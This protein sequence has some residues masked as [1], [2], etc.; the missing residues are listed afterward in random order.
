MIAKVFIWDNNMVTVFDEQGCQVE[1][2]QGSLAQ[3][4]DLILA[5]C[6]ETTIFKLTSWTGPTK[7]ITQAEFKELK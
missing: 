1:E 6:L 5:N 4:K 3:V 2:Y 7:E